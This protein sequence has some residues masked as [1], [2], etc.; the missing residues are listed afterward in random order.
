VGHQSRIARTG[1]PGQ[2]SPGRKSKTRHPGQDIQ[3]RTA[4]T[5]QPGQD[6]QD[7]TVSGQPGQDGRD[8][9]A[10]IEQ[11]LDRKSGEGRRD[12]TAR[13]GQGG[14]NSVLFKGGIPFKT[15]F[16]S[17]RIQFE[18]RGDSNCNRH[19]I[20]FKTT[21]NRIQSDVQS[22]SKLRTRKLQSSFDLDLFHYTLQ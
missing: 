21:C 11:L 20:G 6:S 4:R 16:S 22:D 9:T 15:G 1:Q 8:W 17:I 7:R 13:R 5:E 19:A 12:S 10:R 18:S 14:Q 3:D 2:A